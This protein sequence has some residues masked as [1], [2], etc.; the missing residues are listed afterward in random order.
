M[1]ERK[2]RIN[3]AGSNYDKSFLQEIPLKKFPEISF[4]GFVQKL[5]TLFNKSI[6]I[7]F[8][9]KIPVGNRCRLI[10]CMASGLPIVADE[11]CK[12]GNPF[13]VDQETAF[14]ANSTK[15]FVSKMILCSENQRLRLTIIKKAK[16]IYKNNYLPMS[17]G[18]IFEEF[19]NE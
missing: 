14:L 9:G 12:L 19:I 8:P 11:S 5:E 7:I 1:G 10:T 4:Y 6:A 2:F 13:L 16:K 15:E 17:A 18:K 3:I